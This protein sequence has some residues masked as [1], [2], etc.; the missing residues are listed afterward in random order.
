MSFVKR[1]RRSKV[2]YNNRKPNTRKRFCIILRQY[3][4]QNYNEF[5]TGGK[6]YEKS[7]THLQ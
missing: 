7:T 1:G 5:I 4:I 6:N 2:V 3:S